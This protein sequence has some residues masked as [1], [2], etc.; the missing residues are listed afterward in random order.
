[1][2]FRPFAMERWQSTWEN[3]VRFNLSESGVH[4]L[5]AAELLALAGAD[6]APVLGLPLGYTQSNGTGPL[7]AA[8]AALY[9]GT[10]AANITVTN[11]SAESNYAICWQ[12]LE[13]GD[14]V[15]LLLPNYMQTWGLAHAFEADVHPFHLHEASGWQP[16]PDEVDA[17][18]APGT[19]LVVVTNPNNPTGAV[20]TEAAMRHIIAR[21]DAVGAWILADEVYQGAER[22]DGPP[23]R[24]FWGLGERVIVVNGLSKAYGLPGLRLG[25]SVAPLPLPEAL[26][27]R[28]DYITIGPGAMSDALAVI[29]LRPAVRARILE[30][31]RGIIRTNWQVLADWYDTMGG[32]FTSRAPDAGAISYA[33]YRTDANSSA[34]AE[35]LRRDFDV[36]VVPG[37]QFEMDRF[38]RFGFGPPRAELEAA[39]DRV[40]TAFRSKG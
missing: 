38:I 35:R 30:R 1:M 13:R 32:E 40:A 4:P 20:L 17:A 22:E 12:L 25:W 33:R 28:K 5:T 15:A 31:T 36:L 19:K 11:G 23:T 39:L 8:I 29:A 3:Q 6:A 18:I 24:S 14:R 2:S 26:W 34:F 21:A 10:S 16:D 9:P 27:S 37:D 7:R